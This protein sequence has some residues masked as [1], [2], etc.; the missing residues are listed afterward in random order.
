[1]LW[2][3]QVGIERHDIINDNISG[4]FQTFLQLMHTGQGWRQLQL[5]CHI[6][7][8]SQDRKWTNVTWCHLAFDPKSRHT[9][10]GRDTKVHVVACFELKRSVS[11]VGIA[12]LLS[13]DSLEVGLDA[14]D[15][16]LGLHVKVKAKDC[17]LTRLNPVQRCMTLAAIQGFE[18]VPF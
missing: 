1:M 2:I 9:S 4:Q 18:R 12:F 14:T 5:V 13:P 3:R 10:R 11:L 8:L 6:P 7:Q 15:Y 17:P 16:L